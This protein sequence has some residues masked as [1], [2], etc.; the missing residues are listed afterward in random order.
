MVSVHGF[1]DDPAPG[2]SVPPGR[3]RVTG[4]VLDPSG[5][6]DQALL[7]IGERSPARVILGRPRADVAEVHADVEHAESSGFQCDVDLR[8]SAAGPMS[9]ALLARTADGHWHE[10]ATTSV[11]VT[12]PNGAPASRRPG[13]AFTVVQNEDVM[14]PRWLDYY[15]RHFPA[16]DLYVLDHHTTDGSTDAITDRCQRVPIHWN[17]SFDHRWLRSTVETFQRFLLQS[18]ET[19]LFAEADEFI[20]ADPRRYAGLADYFKRLER[21]AARCTGFEVVHQPDEPP[22]DF[23]AP[24]LAQRG[25]WHAS[26]RYCKRSVSKVPLR[27][28]EGFHEEFIGPDDPP[29]RELLLIHLHRVDYDWCLAR[30]RST[31]SRN[32]SAEDIERRD[33]WQN[34]VAE[35]SEFEQ[36]FRAGPDLEAPREVIPDHIRAVL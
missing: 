31:A 34:R 36:W 17:T 27:W 3:I 8:A 33:G 15:G 20:V 24:I 21:P 28:S 19:V 25:S 10:A 5:P 6:L 12:S 29:D 32:W 35:A 14:L 4:W 16:S 2:S 9:I 1:I 7:I 18:Y 23:D 26:S 22:L 30:H 11:E 13:A